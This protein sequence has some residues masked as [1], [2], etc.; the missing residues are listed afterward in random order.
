MRYLVV[1]L[2]TLFF[3]S[4]GTGQ[5][6]LEKKNKAE[7]KY[8]IFYDCECGIENKIGLRKSVGHGIPDQMTECIH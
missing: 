1:L 6:L 5:R 2:F 4:C 3:V 7:V 8:Y